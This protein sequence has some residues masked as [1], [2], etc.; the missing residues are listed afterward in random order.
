VGLLS[1]HQEHA[2]P[3]LPPRK[4][5]AKKKGAK[6]KVVRPRHDPWPPAA[7]GPPPRAAATSVPPSPTC[8]STEE[9]EVS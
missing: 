9:G 6:Q 8:D 2:I 4:K 7:A 1:N 5:V 3:K